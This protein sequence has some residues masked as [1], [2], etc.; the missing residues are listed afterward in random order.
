MSESLFHLLDLY[1]SLSKGKFSSLERPT[2]DSSI[3]PHLAWK[4]EQPIDQSGW[5][6]RDADG[7]RKED[8]FAPLVLVVD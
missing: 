5:N 3:K 6:E 1:L 4:Q 8:F 7:E 2:N